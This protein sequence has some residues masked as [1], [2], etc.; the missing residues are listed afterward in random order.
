[1]GKNNIQTL[2]NQNTKEGIKMTKLL[3]KN[4]KGATTVMTVGLILCLILGIPLITGCQ[5]G[6]VSAQD[7]AVN[8][9]EVQD[10][11]GG[12]VKVIGTE[13][14]VG[15]AL[16]VCADTD[17]N[18]YVVAEIDLKNKDVINVSYP[19]VGEPYLP[20]PQMESEVLQTITNKLSYA[21][22]EEVA[23]EM[24]NISAE[25]ISGGG[26]YFSVY[27]LDG[28]LLAGNGLFLAFEWVPGEGFSSFT[29]NQAN[30]NSEQVEP[31]TYVIL[32]K[33][34]DYSDATLIT[35]N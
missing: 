24:V 1:M 31:G 21:P 7:I 8:S 18:S 9:P 27:N 22:G 23:I 20:N 14:G 15:K 34:G 12:D 26:V 28:N 17:G 10:A 32:G 16:V 13:I 30:E 2:I 6:V 11:L 19:A 29:W 4:W 35:I 3:V 5:S 25:T 33:A